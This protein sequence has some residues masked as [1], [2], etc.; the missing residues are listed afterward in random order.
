MVVAP[1]CAVTDPS[2]SSFVPRHVSS[3]ALCAVQVLVSSLSGLDAS[4]PLC[5]VQVHVSN[6]LT[7]SVV[8]LWLEASVDSAVRSCSTG[9]G[10]S[11]AAAIGSVSMS[12]KGIKWSSVKVTVSPFGVAKYGLELPAGQWKA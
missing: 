10:S 11:V 5:A 12:R 1:L 3:A 8:A 9:D 6:A 2:T 4:A 7:V